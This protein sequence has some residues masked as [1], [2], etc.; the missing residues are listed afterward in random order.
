MSKPRNRSIRCVSAPG[1]VAAV[2]ALSSLAA[3]GQIT[4]EITAADGS[5]LAIA[6]A[7][8]DDPGAIRQRFANEPSLAASSATGGSVSTPAE[9][10]PEASPTEKYIEPDQAVPTLSAT[11]KFL[12]GVK[13]AFTP[14][15]PIGWFGAAGYAQ[16]RNE[17]PRYGTDGGAFGERLGASALRDVSEDVL[18][19]S[20]MAP[21]FHQDPRYYRLGPSHNFFVRFFHAGFRPI[22]GRTNGGRTVPDFANLAGTL[23]GA[24]LTNAYY[25]PADRTFPQTFKT[26]G[27]SLGGSAAGYVFREFYVDIEQMFHLR[28]TQ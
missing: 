22:I 28:R 25:P 6:V 27:G 2:L 24:A 5:A 11:H 10:L 26:F 12:L 9:S 21:V 19:D 14:F 7:L 8:P 18:A 4:S 23:E 3:C 16:L 1:V 20:V 13:A 17:A 15:A